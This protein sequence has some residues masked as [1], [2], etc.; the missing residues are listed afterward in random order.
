MK[1]SVREEKKMKRELKRGGD[2]AGMELQQRGF[3]CDC[4]A[5]RVCPLRLCYQSR[6]SRLAN[7]KPTARSLYNGVCGV[8]CLIETVRAADDDPKLR[9]FLEVMQPRS[10]G[11]LWTNDAGGAV[12]PAAAV[13]AAGTQAVTAGKRKLK[14]AFAEEAAGDEEDDED[15]ALYQELPGQPGA[16]VEGGEHSRV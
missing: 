13:A 5:S 16:S 1:K 10:K 12:K 7:V 11:A 2:P 14:Q 8:G 15:D 6:H 9:E 4:S 3:C